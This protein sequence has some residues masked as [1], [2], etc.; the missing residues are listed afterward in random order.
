MDCSLFEVQVGKNLLPRS[1]GWEQDLVTQGTLGGGPQFF[2]GYWPEA[3]HPF[4]AN[5]PLQ[6]TSSRMQTKEAL[7]RASRQDGCLS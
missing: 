4:L 3:R 1:R 6:C 2:T 5:G 7:E